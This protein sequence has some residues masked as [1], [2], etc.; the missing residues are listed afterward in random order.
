MRNTEPMPGLTQSEKLRAVILN[1]NIY[2]DIYIYMC[3]YTNIYM[4]TP[5]FNKKYAIRNEGLDFHSK[6]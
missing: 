4:Y 3:V 2:I 1:R 6:K 5:L